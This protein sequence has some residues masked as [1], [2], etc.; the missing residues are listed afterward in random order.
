MTH[1]RH[2]LTAQNGI[3]AEV[4]RQ[5]EKKGI[6]S[7]ADL[8]RA[9]GGDF[10]AGLARLSGDTGV[11]RDELIAVLAEGAK[12]RQP[13]IRAS[14]VLVALALVI[15]LIALVWRLS[16]VWLPS[17]ASFRA[18]GSMGYVVA[19]KYLPAFHIIEDGDVQLSAKATPIKGFQKIED[20]MGHYLLHPLA[21]EE[22][23]EQAQLSPV[24]LTASDM[25]GRV[26]LSIAIEPGALN[27][28]ATPGARVTL[29]LSPR[30]SAQAAGLA[31][32][33]ADAILLQVDESEEGARLTLAIEE[34]KKDELGAALGRSEVFVLYPVQ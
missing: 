21:A 7:V 3:D 9:I 31:P 12:P 32:V 18:Q 11:D 10:D 25:A 23:I 13:G 15:L 2:V 27:P 34:A 24:R 33:E 4:V 5:L 19:A 16:S 22:A 17:D 6:K 20:V 8:W 29:L 14:E 28:N 26:I 30:D 1:I